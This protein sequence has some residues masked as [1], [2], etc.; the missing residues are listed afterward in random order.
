MNFFG[1]ARSTR[2][3]SLTTQRNGIPPLRRNQ[4]GGSAG[5]PIQKD[6]TFIFGDYEGVKQALG[7]HEHSK[8][9]FARPRATGLFFTTYCKTR[10]VSPEDCADDFRS[11]KHSVTLTVDPNISNFLNSNLIPLPNP[12]T[13][14]ARQQFGTI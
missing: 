12:A 6:K 10:T 2:P 14:A 8:C 11:T 9:A 1:T 7:Q 4:Y 5:G 3:I 13:V